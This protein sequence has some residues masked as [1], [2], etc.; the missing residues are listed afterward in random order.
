M[1]QLAPLMNGI[2]IIFL[3]LTLMTCGITLMWASGSANVPDSLAPKTE[4]PIPTVRARPTLGAAPSDDP[5]VE[6][7]PT[8]SETNE[9]TPMPDSN[10]ES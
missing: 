2:T 1:R 4:V 5:T 3:V 7:S 10:G 8:N 9:P 6:T